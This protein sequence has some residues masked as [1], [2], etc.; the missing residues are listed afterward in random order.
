MLE[1]SS[2]EEEEYDT[3]QPP[4]TDKHGSKFASHLNNTQLFNYHFQ[5]QHKQQQQAPAL[6][7]NAPANLTAATA[8]TSSIAPVASVSPAGLYNA[9]QPITSNL[10]AAS[11]PS[12]P[13]QAVGSKPPMNNAQFTS[14]L[15]PL[16]GVSKQPAI[17]SSSPRT[18]GATVAANQPTTAFHS[19]AQL[20][21][22]DDQFLRKASLGQTGA[23]TGLVAGVQPAL[24]PMKTAPIQP[25]AV[26]PLQSSPPI[27]PVAGQIQPSQSPIESLSRTGSLRATQ[28]RRKSLISE[29]IQHQTL[30]ATSSDGAAHV[31]P[32]APLTA[33]ALTSSQQLAPQQQQLASKLPATV[34]TTSG[35]LP[36]TGAY[37]SSPPAKS[38]GASTSAALDHTVS[39]AIGATGSVAL[40]PQT[41]AQINANQ[42]NTTQIVQPPQVSSQIAPQQMNTGAAVA[43][44]IAQ[45]GG[46]NCMGNYPMLT[47]QSGSSGES[48]PNDYNNNPFNS[49]TLAMIKQNSTNIAGS[50]GNQ[51]SLTNQTASLLPNLQTGDQTAGGPV[52]EEQAAM[53]REEQQHKIALQLYVFT[54]RSVSYPFNA[55]QAT[56]MPRRP[57]KVNE[58]Q[59]EL[60]R[61]RFRSLV[62]GELT[63]ASVLA[64][65]KSKSSLYSGSN[66]ITAS[67]SAG[68]ASTSAGTAAG[69]LPA[70]SSTSYVNS[71]QC[72]KLLLEILSVY[73]E[74]FLSSSRLAMLVRSGGA[75]LND[76][77]HVFRKLAEKKVKRS[78]EIDTFQK[79][80]VLNSFVMK[81]DV[82]LPSEDQT[83]TQ[84]YGNYLYYFISNKKFT[85]ATGKTSQYQLQQQ[86]L[87]QSNADVVLTK[88]QM[89]D[90][91]S[92]ILSIKKFEHQLLF[93]ALQV[94]NAPS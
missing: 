77:R 44:A 39:G 7:S 63:I 86:T 26:A 89:Y 27:Q 49:I 3:S 90:M 34:S 88:E 20:I 11:M 81:F 64:S 36:V 69:G 71:P 59:L 37:A 19:S 56:D 78:T 30:T 21:N 92:R 91:F 72:E 52:D 70:N 82:L 67:T 65:S 17:A 62:K 13:I 5:Q 74:Q 93:N 14:P 50:L 83:Y 61:T 29:V 15:S 66:A 6:V 18:I 4:T 22:N 54:V 43:Q 79:E 58:P 1:P 94:G 12:P 16:S 60:I 2:S 28:S 53:E 35:Q 73:N 51:G 85:T 57:F 68:T 10:A 25:S 8:A 76:F 80:Q 48:G 41:S 75:C 46:I 33:S 47:G 84:H 24:L 45:S 31:L 87:Q 9:Q 40:H 23:Y 38:N 32:N 42:V 55:K